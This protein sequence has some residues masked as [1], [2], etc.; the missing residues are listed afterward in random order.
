MT[1]KI[2]PGH[3]FAIY[4]AMFGKFAKAR[5]VE[6]PYGGESFVSDN[7]TLAFEADYITEAY[8]FGDE[9]IDIAEKFLKQCDVDL[10]TSTI[11]FIKLGPCANE[12][13]LENSQTE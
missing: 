7:W 1:I 11:H 10:I 2:E 5:K 6:I 4:S 8:V 13:L 12:Q 9:T 3:D